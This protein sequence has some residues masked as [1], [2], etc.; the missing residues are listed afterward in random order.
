ME[1]LAEAHAVGSEKKKKTRKTR[2]RERERRQRKRT[3]SRR[4]ALSAEVQSIT[5]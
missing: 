2:E 1:A 5:T 4:T 3:S